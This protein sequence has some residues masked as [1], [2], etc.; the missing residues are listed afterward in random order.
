MGV[1]I[2]K[3]NKA[4][5]RGIVKY[6]YK[7]MGKAIIDYDMLSGDDK[8]LVAVSGGLDSLS[9]LRLFMMRSKRVP[10]N[11]E[12]KACFVSTNFIKVDENILIGYFEQN[13]IP[14][15]IKRLELDDR[16]M[17]CFWCSWNRRKVLFETAK[18]TGCNKIALGH[19]LDDIDETILMNLFFFSEISAMKP[20]VNLFDGALD[21]IRPLCYLTKENLQ[22]FASELGL[23]FTNYQ[24]NYGK[25]SR[26]KLVKEVLGRVEQNCPAVK[27][28]IFSALKK[29]KKEYLL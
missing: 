29:I 27:K 23:P 28:N 21:I 5:L 14:F 3:D 22:H 9:L 10:I 26:R 7:K 25:D 2:E 18:E 1:N 15:V 16:D 12:F 11:F 19:H 24:C 20:K 17:N 8:V 13:S 6:A 4:R